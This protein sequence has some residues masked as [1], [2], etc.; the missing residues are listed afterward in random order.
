MHDA[1]RGGAVTGTRGEEAA[2]DTCRRERG[3]ELPS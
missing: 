2:A 3:E 1:S